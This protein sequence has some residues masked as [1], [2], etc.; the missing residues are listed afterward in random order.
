MRPRCWSRSFLHHPRSSGS[1]GDESKTILTRLGITDF[2]AKI[3]T[4]SGG[5]RKRVALAAAL[6]HPA[7]VDP[8]RAHQPP[9]Q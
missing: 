2:E 4:L 1:E 3:G 6:V 5:Q 9:G 7:D 8:G